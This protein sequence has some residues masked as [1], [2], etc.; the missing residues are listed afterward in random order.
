MDAIKQAYKQRTG[1]TLESRVAS[2][3][4]GS[5]KKLMVALLNAS[6]LSGDVKK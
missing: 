2:E 3:T 4:S 6:S 5:Y 1:K